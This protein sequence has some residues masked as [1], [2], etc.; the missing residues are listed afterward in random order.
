[1][2]NPGEIKGLLPESCNLKPSIPHLFFFLSVMQFSG[3]D[4]PYGTVPGAPRSD[5]RPF[6]SSPI[7]SIWQEDV[8]KI[9]EVPRAP[10]NV[11]PARAIT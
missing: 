11:N 6:W 9:L 7:Y 8:S 5:G 1:M 2:Y 10:R 3:L 4:L